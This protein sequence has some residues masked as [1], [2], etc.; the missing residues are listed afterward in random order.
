MVMPLEYPKSYYLC[1]NKSIP[2]SKMLAAINI[3][4]SN[5]R[6]GI[7]RGEQLLSSWVI[8][9]KPFKS[10]DEYYLLFK[11]MYQRYQLDLTQITDIV[12]GSVVPQLT[13][14][15]NR[16]IRKLHGHE[17]TIVDR[18]TSS[19]ISHSSNQMGTDIYAN[20]VAA[21]HLYPGHKIVFDYG[22]AITVTA[23]QENGDILGVIIAP[24]VITSLKALIGD[25][26]QLQEIEIK[27]P[28]NVLGMD[29]ETCLQSGIV[30]GYLGMAEGIIKMISQEQQKDFTV[31]ATGGLGHI[32][33][34]HSD[35][36][37]HFDRFHTLR[38]LKILHQ[39]IH[40]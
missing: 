11:N 1:L 20:A 3:G 35:K 32:Y 36:I 5:I 24:G 8:N 12:V 16:A 7:F 27:K 13:G 10:S 30:N 37:Q 34:S 29:T 17:P 18:Y 19:E 4:N 33:A 6:F 39:N 9:T 40:P 14:D 21:H 31:I 38:G 23:I 26:A 22:T 15:V 28:K 2:Y 25:T